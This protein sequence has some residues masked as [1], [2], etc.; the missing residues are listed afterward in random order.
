MKKFIPNKDREYIVTDQCYW[1]TLSEKEQRQY[2]PYSTNRMPHG[3]Q[4]IDKETGTIV[5]L[6]SGSIIKVIK[7]K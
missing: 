7:S 4:L 3:I 6:L 1:Q 5:N 2:N